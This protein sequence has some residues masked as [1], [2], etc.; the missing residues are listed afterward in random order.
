MYSASCS[1]RPAHGAKKNV[2]KTI[3]YGNLEAW[4]GREGREGGKL[5]ERTH[6]DLRESPD[7]AV[8]LSLSLKFEANTGP[9]P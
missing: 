5:K 3:M 9:L 7:M 2:E 8:C 4:G 6:V 1:V